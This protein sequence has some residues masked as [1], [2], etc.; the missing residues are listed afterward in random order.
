MSWRS[1]KN[2][3]QRLKKILW[4]HNGIGFCGH[5]NV[6]LRKHSSS[7]ITFCGSQRKQRKEG[8]EIH[9]ALV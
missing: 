6:I 7:V 1:Y 3:A 9:Q 8:F 2:I 4:K 5:N